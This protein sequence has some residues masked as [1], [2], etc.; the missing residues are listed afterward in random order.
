[1]SLQ[2]NIAFAIGQSSATVAGLGLAAVPPAPGLTL[3]TPP[4]PPD[5]IWCFLEGSTSTDGFTISLNGPPTVSGYSVEW[6]L[7]IP[8]TGPAPTPN[9]ALYGALRAIPYSHVLDDAAELWSGESDANSNDARILNRHI[10]KRATE[11]WEMFYWPEWT[12]I[13]QRQF[14]PTWNSTSTYNPGNAVYWPWTRAYY[15]CLAPATNQPPVIQ[16]SGSW[17]VNYAYWCL[18]QGDFSGLSM[19]DPA[20][21][22][23][24]GSQITWGDTQL[25]YQALQ[26]APAG[27]NPGNTAYWG[28]LVPFLRNIDYA[29]AW[30]DNVIT[31]VRKIY[32][33]HPWIRPEAC[34]V[35]FIKTNQGLICRGS[36]PI[37][38]VEFRLQAPRWAGPIYNNAL[39]YAAG[40]QAYFNNGS[41]SDFYQ[42]NTQTAP[43]QSP[44]SAP[45]V[46]TLVGFP[47]VFRECAAQAAYADMLRIDGQQD[48]AGPELA[49]AMR[50]L[51]LEF[52]KLERQQG[53]TRPLQMVNA[54]NANQAW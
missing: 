24:L 7:N 3:V 43:G 2:G 37:V 40:N 10:R 46:W 29:Q 13:E 54:F 38:W 1:M 48:K 26:A 49:E 35:P 11:F 20:Q 47:Y 41:S 4:N 5:L 17:T 15:Q 51:R 14:R 30:E 21:S 6:T 18:A 28:L 32:D 36:A 27:T 45:S 8:A 44:I 25:P 33:L 53:Q 12:P 31:E 22:Y 19:Y 9:A 23:T 39:S 34:Q 42:A 50:L 52:D 16:V